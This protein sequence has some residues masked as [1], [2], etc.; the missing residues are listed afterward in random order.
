MLK[1]WHMDRQTGRVSTCRLDPSGRRGQVKR[2][3]MWWNWALSCQCPLTRVWTT[4]QEKVLAAGKRERSEEKRSSWFILSG[5]LNCRKKRTFNLQDFYFLWQNVIY[6]H[7]HKK[8]SWLQTS[9][10]TIQHLLYDYISDS[11]DCCRWISKLRA[12]LQ[13]TWTHSGQF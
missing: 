3:E 11:Y 5:S 7:S 2:P 4:G 1:W 8:L 9:F 10:K 13:P 12:L 6:F